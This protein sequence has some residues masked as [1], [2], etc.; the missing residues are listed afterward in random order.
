MT[1]K[2]NTIVTIDFF[3]EVWVRKRPV[4]ARDIEDLLARIKDCG[5]EGVAWRLTFLGQAAFRSRVLSPPFLDLDDFH[6]T[7]NTM[8][9]RGMKNGFPEE[10]SERRNLVEW[11]QATLAGIDPLAVASEACRKLGLKFIPWYDIFDGWQAGSYNTLLHE[12]PELCWTDRSG[13]KHLRGVASYAFPET[14]DQVVR[15]VEECNAYQPDGFYLCCSCHSTHLAEH[16]EALRDGFGFELPVIERCVRETGKDPRHEKVDIAVLDRIRGEFMTEFFAKVRQALRPAADLHLPLQ[17]HANLVKTSPYWDGPAAVRY[18]QD[19]RTWVDKGIAQGLVLGD[20]ECLFDWRPNWVVKGG[21][22]RR[23]EDSLPV[24][25]LDV[26]LP[27]L[28]WDKCRIYFFSGWIRT[29]QIINN[30]LNVMAEACRKHTQAGGWIHEAA[31]IETVDAWDIL[32]R[33]TDI[34]KEPMHSESL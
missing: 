10:E 30:R 1:A 6:F 34:A 21:L 5:A 18:Y 14:V 7:L 8:K 17:M 20:F 15:V 19:Y 23:P 9:Q 24:D 25:Q 32:P 33:F 11:L 13:T 3:D 12:R 27:D 4:N 31:S 2:R 26:L 29:R 16:P 22:P 28:P